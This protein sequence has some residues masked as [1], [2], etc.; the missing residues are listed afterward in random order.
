MTIF[1]AIFFLLFLGDFV[2]CWNMHQRLR[3]LPWRFATETGLLIFIGLQVAGLAMIYAGRKS[4]INLDLLSG[5]LLLAAIYIWHCLFIFPLTLVWIVTKVG[6]G[7]LF[8]LRTATRSVRHAPSSRA[9][10]SPSKD[11]SR[12][13]FV[14]AA[15]CAA[16]AVVA[17]GT[18]VVAAAQWEEFRIRRITVTLPNLPPALDGLTIA[19]V[20]DLHVGAF[21][22]GAVLDRVVEATNRLQAD[23]VLMPGDLI[24]YS[25]DDLPAGIDVVKR[26]QSTHGVF[27]CEGNHD[28][29]DDRDTFRLRTVNAGLRLLVNDS[30]LVWIRGTE[31]Q[32]LG[33]CWGTGDGDPHAMNNRGDA[34]IASSTKRLLPQLRP[35]AFPILMAH[36][37]HAFDYAGNIPL[38]LAG[39]T[40]GG[41][42]NLTDNLG[43][44]PAMFRYWSGLYQ[45]DGRAVVV[46]NGV[47]NWFPVRIN[48]PAEI[49]HITL[50]VS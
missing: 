49:I 21:T 41:Q 34:A 13:E 39:H 47:G 45:K 23:L 50:R 30:A 42:I 18:T 25:L 15:V 11:M 17:L 24:N 5:R 48:A 26:L 12:R 4:G 8:L 40:H 19:Q 14:S 22:R 43:F 31:V 2:W 37:P 16:P 9:E 46:S 33:L 10:P 36:H 6:Q 3:R 20:S 29:Y 7:I 27:L 28:L 35:G 32:I 44:G 38:T 1:G